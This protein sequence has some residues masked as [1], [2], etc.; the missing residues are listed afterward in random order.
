MVSHQ[1][2]FT[3]GRVDF[4]FFWSIVKIYFISNMISLI[5]YG[6]SYS[7]IILVN[8]VVF[9]FNA[10]TS[11]NAS[12]FVFFFLKTILF[13]IALIHFNREII[14]IYDCLSFYLY[15]A[16]GNLLIMAPT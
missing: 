4:Y 7:N 3:S 9:V 11:R 2:N 5:L 6:L 13:F 15:D 1:Y 8:K 10:V 12:F 14:C 16:S